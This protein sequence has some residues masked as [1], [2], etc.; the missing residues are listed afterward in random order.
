MRERGQ[1]GAR[2]EQQEREGRGEA[3]A[4]RPGGKGAKPG[5]LQ[6]PMP[7][8]ANEIAVIAAALVDLEQRRKLL[9][10]IPP[11]NFFAPGHAEI[12]TILGVL[13]QKG[14]AYDPLTVQQLSNRK[15]DTAYLD[16]LIEQRPAV[17]PNLAH[18]VEMIRVDR[19]RVDGI[20]GPTQAFLD[21]LRDP[22]TDAS[23]LRALA[24]NVAIAFDG[25]G[26]Q[27]FLRD[28]A[29][30]RRSAMEGIK[31]RRS[32]LAVYPFGLPGFD[33]FDDADPKA[34]QWRM[35]PGLF[36]G[37]VTVVTG[38]PGSAKTTITS[39][40]ALAQVGYGR[41]VLYG[42]WEQGAELT[43][44][45]MASQ[46]LGI[47][48]TRLATGQI[49]DEEE[50]AIEAEIERL[51]PFV[52]FCELPFGRARGEKIVNDKS[53]D[54][55]HEMIAV[56]GAE[57]AIFDLWR[58]A[59]GQLKPEDEEQA[60]GRQWAIGQETKCH[61][62]LLHQFRKASGDDREQ[63]SQ[64]R[65]DMKGSAAWTEVPDTILHVH[66]EA[67]IKDVPDDVLRINVWKQ[68]HGIAPYAVDFDWDGDLGRLSNGRSAS[69]ERPGQSGT[70]EHGSG[71]DDFMKGGGSGNAGHARP[72]KG[73]AGR[74]RKK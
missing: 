46:S 39:Q 69:Y 20:R 40:I 23:V 24:K 53:M 10:F 59:M 44:E 32:G 25:H 1:A 33:M 42:A 31:K 35:I 14:L 67:L 38:I 41:R 48:R 36:P 12:W 7:D 43:L 30:L 60:L 6:I 27:R 54:L 73:G 47:S 68:R 26:T 29:Q 49:T 71:L 72:A 74:G 16:S 56:T 34:G 9:A 52:R 15:V 45:L 57:V 28:P 58:K 65:D 2:P 50:L 70:G 61:Q 18:H 62:I 63:R 55:L 66:R 17:P 22:L 51:E 11:D 4:E 37:G 13:E 8:M 21:A 64:S 3:R 5:Q 19:M